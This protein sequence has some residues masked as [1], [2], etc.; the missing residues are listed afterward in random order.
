MSGGFQTAVGYQPSPAVAGDFA[1]A[2]PRATFNAGQFGLVAGANG[3]TIARF[4]WA[5][6]SG[7]DND[8]AP[9]IANNN[10]S[11][12]VSGFVHREQQGLNVTYLSDASMAVQPGFPVTLFTEGDFWVKNDGSGQA[13]VGQYAYADFATGKVSFAAASSANT[14]SGSA[15]SIAAETFS[16][17]GS[18]AG[19]VLTVTAVG[20]GTVVA[21]AL[22]SGTNVATGSTIVSQ[23]SG[24]AG[25]VGT[26]AVSIP[27]QTVA[28]TTI[29]GTYG[30]LTIGGTVSGTIEVGG[31]VGGT[32]VAAG[33]VVTQALTG[34]GGA[35]TYAVNLTQTVASEAITVTTNVQTKWIAASSGAAGEL[36][37]IT[38]WPNG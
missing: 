23:L 27:E 19:N 8:N 13:L 38:S 37:K 9:S 20:S 25:G 36:V 11:G 10:G 12:P 31:V 1:S 29:S 17:T 33:T 2:N 32:S 7:I 3:V 15:S 26:Y 18:I 14:A 5:S 22:I 21:G 35:G 4:A 6:Y 34:T 28:S 24:T 16:V 30:Q